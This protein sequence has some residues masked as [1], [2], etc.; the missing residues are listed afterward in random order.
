MARFIA[1]RVVPCSAAELFAYHARPRA[2]ERLTP[3]WEP[4]DI[5]VPL[6]SLRDGAEVTLKT[7]VGPVPLTLMVNHHHVEVPTESRAGGFIDEQVK[8]PF[9]HW[10]HHHR[11]EP[12]TSTSCTLIDE[13]DY[14]LPRLPFAN[15]VGGGMV[16]QRL[17]RLFR[18]RHHTTVQ[19]LMMAHDR[20][21]QPSAPSLRIG[22][23]GASGLIGCELMDTLSVL[24]HLPIAFVR[25]GSRAKGIT[26]DPAT[27][28][29][30]EDAN[31]LDAVVHLAGENIGDGRLT[32]TKLQRI[33]H[34]RVAH[35]RL[36]RR[37][38]HALKRP[39][40]VFVGASAIGFYGHR[41]DEML[42]ELSP[43]GAGALPNLCSAWEQETLSP[44]TTMRT[45][46]VRVGLVQSMRGGALAKQLPL[47]RMGVGGPLGDGSMWTPTISLDDVAAVFVRAVL[48]D[49]VCGPINATSP[50]PLRN[51]DY[52]AMLGDL[53]HRP[54]VVSVPAFALRAA[55]G[56]L[57]DEGILA[58]ARV[59]PA[60]L[61][62]LGHRFRHEHV[63]AS[64]AHVLGEP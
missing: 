30:H 25:P 18:Y 57:A 56:V 37:S 3:P 2:F 49:R 9:A 46:A 31:G 22:I 8:G 45:V 54:T 13:I 16:V 61:T 20:S 10:R 6:S 38:L 43:M 58:S 7:S 39:P 19:D 44:T 53:L 47:F 21:L 34:E 4:V 23:T 15:I 55:A 41:N 14:A 32:A 64:M 51:R 35:T 17:Q 12:L 50:E 52:T 42:T 36:L 11:F 33:H 28:A 26:W 5:I 48:D 1:E 59:I 62:A 24:G 40:A 27:G 29:L 63:R 60:Q